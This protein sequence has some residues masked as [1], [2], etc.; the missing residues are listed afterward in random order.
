M[1]QVGFTELNRAVFLLKTS[2]GESTFLLFP[3]SR[4]YL[5]SLVHDP[6][7][8]LLSS[9]FC[10]TLTSVSIISSPLTLTL[11]PPSFK[12]PCKIL[13]PSR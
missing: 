11:L 3:A 9:I 6:L 2:K 4:V 5:H 10:T 12:N 8:S 1:F 7:S 13:G